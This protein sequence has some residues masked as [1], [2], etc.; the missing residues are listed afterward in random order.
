M[1]KAGDII[2]AI[3]TGVLGLATVAVVLGKKANSAGRV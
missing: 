2:M 3:I 1:S